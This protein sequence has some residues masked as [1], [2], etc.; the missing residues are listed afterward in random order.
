MRCPKCGAESFVLRTTDREDPHVTREYRC[1]NSHAFTTEEVLPPAV[2]PR[3]LVFTF[4]RTKADRQRW[5]RNQ[6]ILKDLCSASVAQVAVK[7]GLTEARI[8]Q[9]HASV[10]MVKERR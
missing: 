7:W 5:E 1:P 6:Q 2:L 3:E 8:R 10:P 4:R 9:I